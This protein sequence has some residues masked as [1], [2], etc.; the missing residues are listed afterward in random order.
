MSTLAVVK[1]E[2]GSWKWPIFQLVFM[3]ILAYSGAFITFSMLS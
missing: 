1:R 2:T 3:G